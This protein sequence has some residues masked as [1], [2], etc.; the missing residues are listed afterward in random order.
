MATH[1]PEQ[2]GCPP[3]PGAQLPLGAGTPDLKLV[4]LEGER[5]QEK[6]GQEGLG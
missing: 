3:R 1:Q 2:E 6:K 5:P 4:R